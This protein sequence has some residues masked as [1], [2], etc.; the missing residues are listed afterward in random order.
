MLD[1]EFLEIVQPILDLEEF[2]NTKFQ[3]HHGITRYDHSMNVAYITYVVTKNLK[4]NYKEATFA[5][6]IHDFFNDEV[7][8]EN[9]YKRLVDHPKHALKNAMRY[10]ELTDLQKDIIAK[11]MFPVTLTPPKYK[12]SVLVSLIDKYS[13]INERVYS[14]LRDVKE[15]PIIINYHGYESAI[16]ELIYSLAYYQKEHDIKFMSPQETRNVYRRIFKK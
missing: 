9:G 6:L 8:D 7:K 11:H 4:L 16:R 3:R 5:A 13:S 14:S 10:F 2:N 12:E 1:K 15:K